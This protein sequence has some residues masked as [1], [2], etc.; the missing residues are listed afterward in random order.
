MYTYLWFK[1]FFRFWEKLQRWLLPLSPNV[2]SCSTSRLKQPRAQDF[3]LKNGSS[4]KSPGYQVAL[5]AVEDV[6]P[7][8]SRE[9]E[10]FDFSEYFSFYH[11]HFS[12]GYCQFVQILCVL[13]LSP[14]VI[15]IVNLRNCVRPIVVFSKCKKILFHPWKSVVVFGV[16]AFS[17][18]SM[19]FLYFCAVIFRFVVQLSFFFQIFFNLRLFEFCIYVFHHGWIVK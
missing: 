6:L 4:G 19:V 13:F 11:I 12:L 3:S 14:Y 15:A 7:V 8:Y 17:L 1:V 2:N 10:E 5:N 18:V 9:F 16:A